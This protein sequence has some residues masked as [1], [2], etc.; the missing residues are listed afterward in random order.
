MTTMA[1][2]F[3]LKD[4]YEN[5]FVLTDEHSRILFARQE[6]DD[7]IQSIIKRAARSNKPPKFVLYGDWGAGKTHTLNHVAYHLDA[8]EEYPAQV[9]MADFPDVLAKST[10]Q[11]VHAALLDSLGFTRAKDWVIQFQS[12][13][14][15]DAIEIIQKLTQS[16]DIAHAFLSIIGY[17][18]GARTAWDWLRGKSLSSSEAHNAGLPQ[19]LSESNHLVGVLRT[20]G[21]FCEEIEGERLVLMLD[22][23]D[24]LR[25]VTNGDAIAHWTNAFRILADK[26]TTEVGFILAASFRDPDMMPEPLADQQVRTRFGEGAYLQLPNF[27]E[28]QVE[29]FL[30]GL[31]EEWVDPEK[32]EMILSEHGGE[33]DGEDVDGSSF[34]FTE[35]ALIHFREWACRRGNVTTPRDLQEDLDVIVNRAMDDQ[36]HVIADSYLS[37]VLMG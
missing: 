20:L 35:P 36:R 23:A 25:A 33:S 12:R 32:R 16:E 21:M 24:K 34:P 30:R 27:G 14:P 18:E 26:L 22:E 9:I 6:L 2:W 3:G 31:F 28:E 15:E 11:V 13:H 17:G 19:V 4:E 8:N 1:N 37:P 7:E 5:F 10:F 29:E